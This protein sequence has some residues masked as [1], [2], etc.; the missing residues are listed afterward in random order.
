[1][2]REITITLRDYLDRHEA[3]TLAQYRTVIE[4]LREIKAY[5]REQNGRVA[6]AES[7][8]AVLKD[9][10]DRASRH[11]LLGGLVGVL[12]AAAAFWK[13]LEP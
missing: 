1:M 7:A 5:Q 3:Q 9:Q 6:S 2:D 11:G 12:G 4:E 13:A 8:I 10:A